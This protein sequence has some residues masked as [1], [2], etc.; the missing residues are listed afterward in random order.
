LVVDQS[1]YRWVVDVKGMETPEFKLKKRLWKHY[2][3]PMPLEIVKKSGSIWKTTEMVDGP[4]EG[5]DQ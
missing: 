1:G 5:V 3:P 2:G 4:E